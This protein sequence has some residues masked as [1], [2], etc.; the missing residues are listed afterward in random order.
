MESTPQD[1]GGL[2][3]VNA[4]TEFELVDTFAP[5]TDRIVIGE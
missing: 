1:T 3:E 5:L 2:A 4:E